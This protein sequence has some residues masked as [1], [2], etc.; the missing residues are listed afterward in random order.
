M[1][2]FLPSSISG[3]S[4]QPVFNWVFFVIPRYVKFA[5][6]HE[7]SLTFSLLNLNVL[8]CGV[9]VLLLIEVSGPIYGW[10]E[11]GYVEGECERAR[12][13]FKE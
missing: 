7:H 1:I 10:A 8:L 5:S 4:N 11:Y 12:V 9:L 3:V 2:G 6:P 13:C